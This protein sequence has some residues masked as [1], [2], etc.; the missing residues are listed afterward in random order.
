MTLECLPAQSPQSKTKPEP[1][2][3]S[4]PRRGGDMRSIHL[5][6]ASTFGATALFLTACNSLTTTEKLDTSFGMYASKYTIEPREQEFYDGFYIDGVAE[7]AAGTEGRKKETIVDDLKALSTLKS[8]PCGLPCLQFA[9]KMQKAGR[10]QIS[11]VI[12]EGD[13]QRQSA[14]AQLESVFQTT[15]A[16]DVPEWVRQT[17]RVNL[18]DVF[19]PPR[20]HSVRAA[21][22]E[23]R[24]R[25]SALSERLPAAKITKPR[26]VS[27]QDLLLMVSKQEPQKGDKLNDRGAFILLDELSIHLDWMEKEYA[28]TKNDSLW[29]H[30]GE[31]RND[32]RSSS[33]ESSIEYDIVAH[34][35]EAI[36]TRVSSESAL[37]EIASYA[38]LYGIDETTT[39][40]KSPSRERRVGKVRAK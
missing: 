40:P 17:I 16:K 5:V 21:M 2:L 13:S 34:A 8:P 32:I 28:R 18:R 39:F 11:G 23:L 6:I 36:T 24:R 3:H 35:T 27:N 37:R 10:N 12:N 26:E 7:W 4:N 29:A 14:K 1:R 30:A 20:V 19:L 25:E 22:Y 9:V 15:H 38:P 31:I 33:V